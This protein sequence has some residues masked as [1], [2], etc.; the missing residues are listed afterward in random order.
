[1]RN[2]HK[3]GAPWSRQLKW[4]TAIFSA[5][6]V[7]I[8]LI[9]LRQTPP[10]APSVYLVSIWL[11]LAILALAALFAVRGYIIEGDQLLVVRPLWQTRLTLR[12]LEEAEADAEAMKGSIRTF[13][14]GG[15]FGFIGL[16]RNTKIGRYRAFVTDPAKCVVL[17]FPERTLVISPD[18]PQKMVTMLQR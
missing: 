14:N 10:D 2:Q 16:F 11:P 13:G 17:R 1:M 12:G 6:L 5:V 3:F 7:L 15:L 8:P 4:L 18:N 9:M